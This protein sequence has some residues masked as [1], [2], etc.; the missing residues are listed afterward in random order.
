MTTYTLNYRFTLPD[1][2]ITGWNTAVNSNFTLIDALIGQFNTGIN[3]VGLWSNGTNYVA[4]QTVI[5]TLTAHLWTCVVANTSNTAPG[6]FATDRAANPGWWTDITNP[7]VSAQQAASAASTS[8]TS[9]A[10]SASA[11]S[12][13]ATSAA[14]SA[15]TAAA[16]TAANALLKGNNLSDLVSASTARTNLGLGTA[17][18]VNTGTTAGT[19]ADGGALTSEIARAMAA[20]ATNAPIASPTFTGT[21]QAPTAP[22]GTNTTQ[23]ATMAAISNAVIASS[24]L[25]GGNGTAGETVAINVGGSLI[26]SGNTLDLRTGFGNVGTLG[27]FQDMSAVAHYPGDLVAG[28]SLQWASAGGSGGS[29]TVNF[30]TWMCLGFI[31]STPTWQQSIT[32]WQRMY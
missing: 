22:V 20:E 30:G 12:T 23:I 26:L 3:L 18:L 13:S 29:W 2:D 9:A 7:A 32:L 5:D 31:N 15:A 17:A 8:A 28:T 21:P 11:A 4:G 10:T 25:L 27:L 24:G 19:A 16:A 6:L 14:A 1:Y